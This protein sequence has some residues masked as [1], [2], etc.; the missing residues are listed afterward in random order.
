MKDNKIQIKTKKG[1]QS[2]NVKLLKGQQVNFREVQIINQR[3][4]PQLMPVNYD[5]S[6]KMIS[7]NTT[8]CYSLKERF[9]G[10]MNKRQFIDMLLEIIEL[11]KNLQDKVMYQ[12]N[13]LLDFDKIYYTPNQMDKQLLF[14]YIPI[15]NYDNH[16]NM[17]DY[18]MKMP[19]TIVFNNGESLD[20]VNEFIAYFNNNIN[21]SVYDFEMF[22]HRMA[23]N[24]EPLKSDDSKNQT[25]VEKTDN[26]ICPNCGFVNVDEAIY[27]QSCG[28]RLGETV[29]NEYNPIKAVSEKI[30]ERNNAAFGSERKQE[31]DQKVGMT[32][33]TTFLGAVTGSDATVILTPPEPEKKAV[34]IRRKNNEKILLNLPKFI[35]GKEVAKV[36]YAIMNNNTVSRTHAFFAKDGNEF[37]IE[38][39]S[40]TNG[41]FVN[42]VR[43]EAGKPYK[44]TDGDIIR[45]S[46][47]EFIFECK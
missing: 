13:L 9:K 25:N 40:S 37:C 23:G 12:K 30:Y 10:V 46:D 42:D 45:L 35:V 32:G 5:D 4:I 29:S 2:I 19:Y 18:F 31:Q 43:L 27:C 7:F 41:T 28:C 44:I 22:V 14:L 38:D 3:A 1:C 39:M 8:G 36:N 6:A 26:N 11:M 16:V 34:L 33:G 21:F 20:Y 47:E 15:M 24:D 17:K